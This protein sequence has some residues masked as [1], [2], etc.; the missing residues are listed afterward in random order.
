MD[1]IAQNDLLPA[2][3]KLT[4]HLVYAA[5]RSA[6]AK[7]GRLE[8]LPRHHRAF[9]R[10]YRS[11]LRAAIH[12][13]RELTLEERRKSEPSMRRKTRHVAEYNAAAPAGSR[14]I[15]TPVPATPDGIQEPRHLRPNSPP[16]RLELVVVSFAA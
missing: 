2:A 13:L 16:V 11:T 15:S 8:F 4:G 14:L 5:A 12:Q 6:E 10:E 1:R 9:S 3:R 7:A